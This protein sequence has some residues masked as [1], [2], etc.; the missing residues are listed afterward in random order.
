[1]VRWECVKKRFWEWVINS[2]E[3][4]KKKRECVMGVCKKK[5]MSVRL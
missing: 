3:C 2:L 5:T 1:M 4:V